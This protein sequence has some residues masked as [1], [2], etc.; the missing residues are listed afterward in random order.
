MKSKILATLLAISAAGAINNASA[1][2]VCAGAKYS[3]GKVVPVFRLED[4]V[5]FGKSPFSLKW[6]VEKTG[7]DKSPMTLRINPS[8]SLGNGYSLGELTTYNPNAVT[9]SVEL[10]K[11]IGN[12]VV[13]GSV[14]GVFP[15]NSE[16]D[17]SLTAY[18]KYKL[19]RRF[20]A[21][22]TTTSSV[23]NLPGTF[24]RTMLKYTL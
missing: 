6:G 24:V 19:S 12:A 16:P 17:L 15:S 3:A 18:G 21:D 14:G 22:L 2:D 13:S 23:H 9:A 10:A 1:L 11:S 20:V 5:T 8:Y 4:K 7:L